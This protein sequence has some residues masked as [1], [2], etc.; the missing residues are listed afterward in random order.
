MGIRQTH[1][2]A[3]LE[4]SQSA[5]DEVSR[6]L[7]EAGYGHVFG[8]GHEHGDAIDMRGIGVTREETAT[9]CTQCGWIV[10]TSSKPE[11][12]K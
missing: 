5:Y 2:Y 3:E 11:F 12:P 7:V 10:D 8:V 9:R 1:T 4:L 6:K